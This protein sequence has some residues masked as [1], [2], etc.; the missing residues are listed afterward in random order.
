MSHFYVACDLGLQRGRIMLGTLHKEQLTM[1]EIRAFP[2]EPLEEKGARQWNVPHLYNEILEGLRSAGSYDEPVDSVS[3]TSWGGDY[4]LFQADGTLLTPASHPNAARAAEGMKAVLA[5][6]PWETIYE[7]T[8]T[9]KRPGNT[10]FQLGIESAKRLRHAS[11]LLP[12]ADGFNYLLAGVPRVETSLAA[13]TQ[14]YNPLTRDWS[15]TLINALKLSPEFL[16][17]LVPAGTELGPLREEVAKETKMHDA[18]VIA[19]CSHE[20]AAALAGL[21]VGNGENW[22]FLR[23]G[24]SAL[25]GSV[26]PRPIINEVSRDLNFT[27]EPGYGGSLC[28]YKPTVGLWLLEECQRFWEKEN[29]QLDPEML[30]HLAGAAEPFESLIDPEDPRFRQPGDMPLKIQAY[31]KDTDQVVPRKP[32]PVFRCIL[33]S[34]ALH[35]RKVLREVTYLTGANLSRLYFLGG[36]EHSLLNHFT[37]NALQLPVVVMPSELTAIGNVVVQA[38]ALG[39]IGS[40]GE[41]RR[42]VRESIK[43]ETIMPHATAWNAAYD[44][45]VA[46]A[47]VA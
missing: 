17:P 13:T 42:M 6:V 1:S 21:P 24:T 39:H 36:A 33:E 32:G 37:A 23:P 10:L 22:A 19:S 28:F 38:L 18:K 12:I 30:G 16:P 47:P 35:Y 15:G 44:R 45:F 4:L 43:T 5:K 7:E 41:A 8:G 25:V 20:I 29:R 3:C 46:L 9:V 11:H 40:L 27:N 2:N 31:C 14:L 34:L 26:V